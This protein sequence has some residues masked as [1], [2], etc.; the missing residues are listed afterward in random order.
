MSNLCAE[1]VG[2]NTIDGV[3]LQF[4]FALGSGFCSK[5]KMRLTHETS[6]FNSLTSY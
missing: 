4:G 1:Q 6:G 5:V 2:H 3:F